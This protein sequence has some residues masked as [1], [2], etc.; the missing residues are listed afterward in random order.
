MI[1]SKA[2]LSR[3]L[4]AEGRWKEAEEFKNAKIKE[5]RADGL[6]RPEAQASA[7]AALAEKYPPSEIPVEEPEF[8]SEEVAGLPAGSL[9]EFMKD[10]SWVYANLELKNVDAENA[11][12]TGALALLSWARA[13][14]DDFFSK[15]V[16]R[17][18][19]HQEKHG[20]DDPEKEEAEA[21]GMRIDDLMQRAG[22]FVG[23]EE[24]WVELELA[25]TALR[26]SKGLSNDG[27][28][29]ASYLRSLIAEG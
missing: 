21:E 20:P 19:Q 18:L 12:S 6:L 7:W 29:F 15:I 2:E 27:V 3:R 25:T 23:H 9:K 17:V 16:P 24:G 4:Q 26:K 8:T 1:E 13:N 28:G 22:D 5:L 10:A 11:P 14:K